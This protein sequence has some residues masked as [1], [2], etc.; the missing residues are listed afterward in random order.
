MAMMAGK[1]GVETKE[2]LCGRNIQLKSLK[3]AECIDYPFLRVAG[4]HW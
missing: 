3:C 1:K 2:K 4:G